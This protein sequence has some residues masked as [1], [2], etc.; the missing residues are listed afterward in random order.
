MGENELSIKARE[1]LKEIAGWVMLYGKMPSIRDLM[2]KMGYKSPRS[3]MLL[4]EELAMNGFLEKK[5]DGTFKIVNHLSDQHTAR[6]I[7]IPLLGNV[8]CGAP[9]FA[10]EN[11]EAMIPVS[12]ALARQGSRYFL[13]R[14]VGN[15]M[16]LAGIDPG[17]LVLVK[18][19]PTA[20][21]GQYVVAL[22]DDEAT[23]K[24]FQHKGNVVTL[25]PRSSDPKHK[26][27]ILESNFQIQ[28]VVVTTVGRVEC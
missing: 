4:L 15:S 16:N 12:T 21:N 28:G 13:L 27:I 3:P 26:P 14:A 22:I 17:D 6:T 1:A 20:E 9:M 23:I 25:L 11:I 7:A 24:E 18:Q 8:S 10:E 2:N 19:Q 5:S